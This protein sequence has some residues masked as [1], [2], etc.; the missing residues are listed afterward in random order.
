MPTTPEVILYAAPGCHLCE[1]AAR[2]LARL[3]RELRFD[4]HEVDIHS[5]PTL[6]RRYLLEIPVITLDGAVIAQA[7]IEE[8]ALRR[9]LG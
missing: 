5:D 8:R 4:W 7:P 3:A 6:E 9:A 2:L 1:E